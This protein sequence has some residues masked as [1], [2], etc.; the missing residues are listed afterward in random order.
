MND[1]I[2]ELRGLTRH[3]GEV[4]AVRDVDLALRQGE[5]VSFLGPS[6]SGKTTTL[7]MVA[8]LL[9]PTSGSILLHGQE[10]APMP[11]YR[12]NIGMV[13]QN[14]AL[15]PHL[16]V[17]ANV[18]FPLEMRRVKR[19]EIVRR[20][21][22]ALALVGLPDHGGRLPSQLSGGQQ[23]RV[24]LARALVYEPPLLLMDEPLGA[25]DKKLREQMQL[26]ITRLHR[27]LG[28]TVLY[29][30]HDQEEAL[31]MSDR[32]AIFNNGRIEQAGRPQDVYERP[33]TRFVAGFIGESSFIEGRVIAVA[34]GQAVLETAHGR[35]HGH[36]GAPFAVGDAAVLAVRPE[37]IALGT[38][39]ANTVRATLT[40]LIYFGESYK[41]IARLADGGEISGRLPLTAGGAL[42]PGGEVA[43]CWRPLEC[44]IL[45]S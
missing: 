18:A 26:E 42:H 44:N 1:A 2:F 34:D 20:V 33:A 37:R 5:F 36:A 32:I 38:D 30:T 27:E 6:G 10:L 9:A 40:E 11:P 4:V 39:A 13:F 29:V 41:F 35:L 23:Q 17:A 24:A 14:Y 3:F 22:D 19:A 7:M 15:F 16:T 31:V 28:M 12:R 8:G 45:P 25:L 43:L 21:R